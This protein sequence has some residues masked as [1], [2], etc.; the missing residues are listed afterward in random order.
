MIKIYGIKNCD[1]IK[2]TLK[3]FEAH[4]AD[5]QFIDYKKEPPTKELAATFLNAL[6]WDVVINKRG[7]TWRKLDD[8]TKAQMDSTLAIETMVHSPSIIKRPIIEK[9]GKIWSGYDENLFEELI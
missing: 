6:P 2:K 8:D 1:T 4:N 9:D 7:T 5:Y 3:W